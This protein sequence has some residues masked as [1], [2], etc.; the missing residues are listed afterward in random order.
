MQ[1]SCTHTEEKAR[2]LWTRSYS[3]PAADASLVTHLALLTHYEEFCYANRSIYSKKLPQ[4][5]YHIEGPGKV[6]KLTLLFFALLI[7]F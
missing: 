4:N 2:A 7:Y 5:S 1:A 3:S 6:G